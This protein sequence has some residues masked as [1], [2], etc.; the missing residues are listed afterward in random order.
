[1]DG[2]AQHRFAD[3]PPWQHE[4]GGI[5]NGIN[6][7][8]PRTLRSCVRHARAGLIE[9]DSIPATLGPSGGPPVIVRFS[10][11]HYSEALRRELIF[12]RHIFA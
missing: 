8:R 4:H 5:L 7:I 3:V 12:L 6:E 2:S 11:T 9:R 10:H 1:V